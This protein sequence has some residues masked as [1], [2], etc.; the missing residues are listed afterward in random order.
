MHPSGSALPS[1]NPMGMLSPQSLNMMLLLVI[2]QSFLKG[3]TTSLLLVWKRDDGSSGMQNYEDCKSGL[4][5]QAFFFALFSVFC[6]PSSSALLC[7]G[8]WR[9]KPF[10]ETNSS[11]LI[12]ARRQYC[13]PFRW[14]LQLSRRWLYLPP[15]CLKS[16]QQRP[17]FKS[18]DWNT[19]LLRC[20]VGIPNSCLL[21]RGLGFGILMVQQG[22]WCPTWALCS[23]RWGT[24][25]TLCWRML[26]GLIPNWAPWLW[27]SFFTLTFMRT[28][29]CFLLQIAFIL[30]ED[31]PLW[32][33][34]YCRITFG[35]GKVLFQDGGVLGSLGEMQPG[36]ICATCFLC[37][38]CPDLI[39]YYSCAQCFLPWSDARLSASR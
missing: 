4:S 35:T 28:E 8:W 38:N 1:M 5:S 19:I 16:E 18:W 11:G 12:S 31:F 17:S 33:G 37:S 9:F 32:W 15:K 29:Q 6:F 36:W 20:F 14:H 30:L 34:L 23:V 25:Q 21:R 13:S 39:F 3:E 26:S 24:S 2:I 22:I 27:T 10:A 7:F